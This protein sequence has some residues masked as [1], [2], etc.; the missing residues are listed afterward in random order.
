MLRRSPTP[1]RREFPSAG[2]AAIV[3]AELVAD[4]AVAA[5]IP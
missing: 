5:G 4:R 2:A 3:G 1:S